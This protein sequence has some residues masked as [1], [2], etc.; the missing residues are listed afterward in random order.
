MQWRRRR[1]ERHRPRRRWLP[2]RPTQ[3]LFGMPAMCLPKIGRLLAASYMHVLGSGVEFQ[4]TAGRPGWNVGAPLWW[5]AQPNIL[6]TAPC[7]C[8]ARVGRA[9]WRRGLRWRWRIEGSNEAASGCRHVGVACPIVDAWRLWHAWVD[10]HESSLKCSGHL[11]VNKLGKEGPILVVAWV[12]HKLK[13]P[14]GHPHITPTLRVGAPDPVGG[15]NAL[16]RKRF[17]ER[18][19]VRKAPCGFVDLILHPPAECRAAGPGKGLL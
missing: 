9:E 12:V 1:R 17:H 14:L 11:R 4:A 7:D 19:C 10:L 16:A 8:G 5:I 3:E 13:T 6:K 15:R 2:R 18:L